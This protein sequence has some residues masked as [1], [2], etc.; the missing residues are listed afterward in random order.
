MVEYNIVKNQFGYYEVDP[1]PDQEVLDRFYQEKYF[2]SDLR[3]SHEYDEEERA[4]LQRIIERKVALLKK[5]IQDEFAGK[6]VLEVGVGE[7]WTLAHLEKEGAIPTGID[8]SD[9]AVRQHNPQLADK[10]IQDHPDAAIER[11]VSAG[12][13][14]DVM[15]LDNVLEHSPTPD[16]LLKNLFKLAADDSVLMVEVPNDYSAIQK[17]C[18]DRGLAKGNYWECPPEHLSYF[19]KSGLQQLGM[20]CGWEMV[21]AI[22][23]FPID[24]YL[25]N[26]TSNYALDPSV[27]KNAHRARIAFELMMARQ[28]TDDLIEFYRSMLGVGLGRL[29]TA[30]FV[31]GGVAG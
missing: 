17:E 23:D 25:F 31:K 9:Y 19:N 7:G 21:D 4:Y 28:D 15:W 6:R 18:S 3:Y 5:T 12:E 8:Y 27:G 26:E 14:Y 13:K 24:L 2:Q 22:A 30:V 16:L 29:I 20:S 1:K 10:L 11:L